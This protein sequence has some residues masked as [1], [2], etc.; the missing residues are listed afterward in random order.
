MTSQKTKFAVYNLAGKEKAF[1]LTEKVKLE[2]KPDA[3][4]KK[5]I[6]HSI[7]IVDRSGSMYYDIEALKET[8]I[9][10]LTLDEY[11][12]SELVVTLISYSSKGDLTCHFQ[13]VPIQE[14]MQPDSDYIADI[15]AIRATYLTCISQSLKLAN[16]LIHPDELTAIT[17][18]SDG[19]ANDSSFNSES[20]AIEGICN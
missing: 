1:Y 10:L 2:I 19:Y 11:S 9:K 18:H 4:P 6:A 14:V 12:N 15:K 16:E 7:M 5:M 3:I 13:R 17:L 20:K 8:L